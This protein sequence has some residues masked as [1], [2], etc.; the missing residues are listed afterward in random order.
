LDRVNV[1]KANVAEDDFQ[2]IDNGDRDN[3]LGFGPF[4]LEDTSLAASDGQLLGKV[5]K[6]TP[7]CSPLAF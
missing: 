6:A 4:E 3:P 1:R 5:S 2:A 7:R